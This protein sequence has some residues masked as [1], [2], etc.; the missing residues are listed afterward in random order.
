MSTAPE[1]AFAKF[2]KKTSIGFINLILVT[3]APSL[4]DRHH[5]PLNAEL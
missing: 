1:A 2:L 5:P 3:A 4:S